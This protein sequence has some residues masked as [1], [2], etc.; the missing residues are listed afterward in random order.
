[1][2]EFYAGIYLGFMGGVVFSIGVA[3]LVIA[4]GGLLKKK[5]KALVIN[6]NVPETERIETAPVPVMKIGAPAINYGKEFKCPQSKVSISEFEC[7]FVQQ[8]TPE[9]C[10]NCL[11]SLSEEGITT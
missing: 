9:N 4:S 11:I 8:V 1:M 7:R 2:G 3:L 10:I 5:E 6:L